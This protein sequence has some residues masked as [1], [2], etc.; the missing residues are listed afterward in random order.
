MA[1][2]GPFLPDITPE[3]RKLIAI[4]LRIADFRT[5]YGRWPSSGSTYRHEHI[6]ANQF[7]K[8]HRAAL[9]EHLGDIL[10][11]LLGDDAL[12]HGGRKSK[13]RAPRAMKRR[14][15][16]G[17]MVAFVAK[18]DALLRVRDELGGWPP[19]SS[20]DPR[21]KKLAHFKMHL[22]R[23][24]HPDILAAIRERDEGLWRWVMEH[25]KPA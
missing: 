10:V 18:L 6:L 12:A 17:D 22:T 11:S 23:H 19:R 20:T 3:E 15:Y 14:A 25:R 4:A 13:Y 16:N 9:S 7:A 21:H 5:A 24:K 2:Y 1:V 8:L